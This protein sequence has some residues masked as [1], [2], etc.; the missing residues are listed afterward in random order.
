MNQSE[1][2]QSLNQRSSGGGPPQV[3]TIYHLHS[4]SFGMQTE[5]ILSGV[6]F[7][8]W[9]PEK[10]STKVCMPFQNERLLDLRCGIFVRI[11]VREQIGVHETTNSLNGTS[12]RRC[13]LIDHVEYSFCTL[14]FAQFSS[15][16]PCHWHNLAFAECSHHCNIGRLKL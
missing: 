3:G 6:W 10:Q 13:S 8:N 5:W 1:L 11:I 4:C 2:S 16:N 9:I 15:F 7:S 14:A 12:I